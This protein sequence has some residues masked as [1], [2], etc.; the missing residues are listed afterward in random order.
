MAGLPIAYFPS[1]AAASTDDR[2]TVL[3]LRSVLIKPEHCEWLPP[4]L[5][6]LDAAYADATE[7][8]ES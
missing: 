3:C 5:T 4:I 1:L 8:V 2:D 7:E 6:I